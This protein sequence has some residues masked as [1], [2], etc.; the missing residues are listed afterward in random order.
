M[1]AG[2]NWAKLVCHFAFA[3]NT[4][5]ISSTGTTTYETVFGLKPQI[6]KS[7]KLGPVRD[8]NYLCQS[9]FC[10]SLTN[11]SHMNKDTNHSPID[12]LLTLNSSIDLVN[13]ETQFENF[14]RKKYR[15]IRGANHR[16]LSYRNMSNLPNHYELQKN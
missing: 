2:N 1:E 10:Q 13:Q 15:K 11:L 4:S 3:H 9:E 5:V 7:L 12:V 16:F 14:Y 8:D 6:P